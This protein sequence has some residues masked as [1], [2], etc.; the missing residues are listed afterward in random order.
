VITFTFFNAHDPCARRALL[1]SFVPSLNSHP[2][3]LLL[4]WDP[5][6]ERPAS[7]SVAISASVMAAPVR[8]TVEASMLRIR[9]SQRRAAAQVMNAIQS[10]VTAAAVAGEPPEE[11]LPKI[12]KLAS[13]FMAQAYNDMLNMICDIGSDASEG[14]DDIAKITTLTDPSAAAGIPASTAHRSQD[15]TQTSVSA[16]YIED[17]SGEDTQIAM[18][19]DCT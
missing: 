4:F 18:E 6:E 5:C 1:S 12:F 10:L 19:D 7:P 9:A 14:A 8:E 16:T 3:S 17:E 11:V 13:G 2:Q 15:A